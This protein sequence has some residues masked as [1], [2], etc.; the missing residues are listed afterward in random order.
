M[1]K[2][3]INKKNIC[4]GV[5]LSLILSVV[6]T[7]CNG[8]Q[9]KYADLDSSVHTELTVEVASENDEKIMQQPT[10]LWHYSDNHIFVLLGY[11]YDSSEIV[12]EFENKLI[13]KYGDAADGGM[14]KAVVFPEDFKRGSRSYVSEL[15]SMISS[16]GL[17]GIIL[18]GAPEKTHE[19]IARIQ[20]EYNSEQPFPIISFFPQDDIL[21]M[22]SAADIVVDKSQEADF[23]GLVKNEE[24]QQVVEDICDIVVT[25]TSYIMQINSGLPKDKELLNLVKSILPGKNIVPYVDPET[26][27][28]SIN[29]FVLN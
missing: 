2:I 24:E 10:Q 21:G 28:Q 6:A 27:L 1:K 20:D 5:I 15:T 7:S 4:F 16:D 3:E 12:N 23:D 19:S 11:G 29:H 13:G 17:K 8:K 22:E 14:V 25:T 18:I 26:G 9:K